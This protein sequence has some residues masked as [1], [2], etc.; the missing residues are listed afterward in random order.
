M[1][2]DRLFGLS[3]LAN[4]QEGCCKQE[5]LENIDLIEELTRVNIQIEMSDICL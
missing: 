2:A 4:S 5:I 3:G 1:K